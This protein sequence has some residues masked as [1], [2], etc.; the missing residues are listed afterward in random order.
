MAHFAKLDE[1]NIV[2]EVI[3]VNNSDIIDENGQESEQKGIEFCQMLHGLNTVWRQTSYNSNFRGIFA[4]IGMQYDSEQD[5]F[6]DPNVP[7]GLNP[8]ITIP[9][10]TRRFFE[11]L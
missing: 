7:T 8:T 10:S 3:V 2:I 6:I 1:N 9:V 11:H 4:G 5:I